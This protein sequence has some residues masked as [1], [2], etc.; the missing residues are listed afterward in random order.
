MLET[1]AGR[2]AG[3]TTSNGDAKHVMHCKTSAE[4]SLLTRSKNAVRKTV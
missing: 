4:D 3:V 2:Y 1:K